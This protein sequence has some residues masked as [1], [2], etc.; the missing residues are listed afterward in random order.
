MPTYNALI[1]HDNASPLIPEG[2]VREIFKGVAA[3]S[4]VFKL[5]RRLPNMSSNRTRIKVLDS[6]PV[7]Y[8]QSSNTAKKQTRYTVSFLTL[9]LLS[10][11]VSCQ[12]S[13]LFEKKQVKTIITTEIT[14]GINIIAIKA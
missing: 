3:E 12:T 10:I 9:I 1:S 8:W 2:Q 5:C 6:L 14:N 7:V 11:I 13:S 4:Q